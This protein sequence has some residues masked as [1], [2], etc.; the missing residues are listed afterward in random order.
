M[1]RVNYGRFVLVLKSKRIASNEFEAMKD[2]KLVVGDLDICSC[3]PNLDS[4]VARVAI[5][6]NELSEC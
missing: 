5:S 1:D 4:T 3:A 2:G 6:S